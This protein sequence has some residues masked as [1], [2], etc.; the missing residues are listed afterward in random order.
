MVNCAYY[1][2]LSFW[3][4]GLIKYN[5]IGMINLK[6]KDALVYFFLESLKTPRNL[7]YIYIYIYI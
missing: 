1:S 2:I 3:D 5:E 7:L 6:M 4:L